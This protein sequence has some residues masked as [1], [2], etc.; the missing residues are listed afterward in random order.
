MAVDVHPCVT[1]AQGIC[2][3][4]YAQHSDKY[5]VNGGEGGGGCQ[6]VNKMATAMVVHT[7][8]AT[9]EDKPWG[10]ESCTNSLLISV[11]L[12]IKEKLSGKVKLSLKVS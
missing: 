4:K 10:H 1:G 9:K 5:R 8:S 7:S 12:L 2:N 3:T 11:S 6:Q